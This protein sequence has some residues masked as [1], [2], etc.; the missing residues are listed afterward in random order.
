MRSLDRCSPPSTT[1]R[2]FLW[3]VHSETRDAIVTW[4]RRPTREPIPYQADGRDGE[5]RSRHSCESRSPSPRVRLRGGNFGSDLIVV[6]ANQVFELDTS[7]SDIAEALSRIFL[8]A[9]SNQLPNCS[10][11]IGGEQRPVG[12]AVQDR[13]GWYLRPCRPGMPSS[14][15]HFVQHA[16]ERQTSLRL[17]TVFPRACPGLM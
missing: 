8:E 11:R 14:R 4:R 12:L 13:G 2:W 9:A 3:Q 16:T 10:W 17:S 15:Q 1:A 5:K 6:A 7:I